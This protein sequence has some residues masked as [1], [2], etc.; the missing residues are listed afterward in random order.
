[1]SC[2]PGRPS[3]TFQ[4]THRPSDGVRVRLLVNKGAS[5]A[6]INFRP[7]CQVTWCATSPSTK[8]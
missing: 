5:M 8:A 7:V 3:V 6:F 2:C 4:N 1:M